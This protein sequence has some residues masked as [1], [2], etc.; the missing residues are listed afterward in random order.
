M[1][2]H[3]R[4]SPI[5]VMAASVCPGMLLSSASAEFSTARVNSEI[6]VSK[7]DISNV[8]KRGN[9]FTSVS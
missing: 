4:K 5:G 3:P 1:K 8:V 2:N 7:L 6:R 9:W